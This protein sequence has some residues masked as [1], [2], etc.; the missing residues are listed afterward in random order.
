MAT[1]PDA[2]VSYSFSDADDLTSGLQHSLRS[3]PNI[4]TI[5]VTAEDGRSKQRYTLN[6]ARGVTDNYGWKASDDL[7]GL[8]AAGNLFP[9]GLWADDTHFYVADDSLDHIYVYNRD[10]TRVKS[11]EIAL[12]NADFRDFHL[13]VNGIW[14]DGET[15]WAVDYRSEGRRLV[16]YSL[17][18][19]SRDRTKEFNLDPA[20]TGPSDIW[21]NNA[22]IW[23][24]DSHTRT[25]YAYRLSDGER[26]DTKDIDISGTILPFGLWSD[27]TTIW[28]SDLFDFPAWDLES[29]DRASDR[30]FLIPANS[31]LFN[32]TAIW[33]DGTTMWAADGNNSKIFSF[34]VPPSVEVGA[35][36]VQLH[37]ARG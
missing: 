17:S 24:L 34:N 16:A 12:D 1:D 18:D 15:M 32:S 10:G 21:S 13:N 11:K 9:V 36:C 27:G 22:T 23:V 19:G 30:D 14:S 7:D 2:T 26:Q 25:I 3:G 28:V 4:V 37:R 20:N 35:C 33:S 8:I 31:G 6:I 5:T 29:G